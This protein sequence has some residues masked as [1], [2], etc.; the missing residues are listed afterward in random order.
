MEK[1]KIIIIEGPQG[2]GKSTL[3]NYL[4]DNMESTNLF[5]LSG[6]KDKTNT[7]LEY[8]KQMYESL[9]AYLALMQGVPADLVFDR[10]FMSE[11]V[12]ARLGY[13]NYIFTDSYNKFLDK[14]LQLGYEYIYLSLYLNNVNLFEERLERQHHNYQEFS[15]ENSVNQ[16]NMYQKISDELKSKDNIE[17]H[18]VAMDDF[19]GSYEEIKKI[20]KLEKRS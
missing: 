20:L 2:T 13:K 6:Q 15:L 19:L 3:A 9:Y 1:S 18:D 12:Y 5:R 7:G 10:F 8:S 17:V 11:E 4:R 14:Y 16:Q